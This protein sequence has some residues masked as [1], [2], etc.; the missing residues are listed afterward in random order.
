MNFNYY[1][2]NFAK[3]MKL[4]KNKKTLGI[5][6]RYFTIFVIIAL[7]A[8]KVLLILGIYK[9]FLLFTFILSLITF[10]ILT[11]ISKTYKFLKYFYYS[12][13][14]KLL[15]EIPIDM[16]QLHRGKSIDSIET[17]NFNI[18]M[19]TLYFLS[20]MSSINIKPLLTAF[21]LIFSLYLFIL[22]TIISLIFFLENIIN[23]CMTSLI[24]EFKI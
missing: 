3:N 23:S 7:F 14:S 9:Y 5:Q 10:V 22:Y 8:S 11:L 12:D 4:N 6:K 15:I 2:E 13:I 1:N 16:L 19:H 17:S 21:A 18:P 24:L 20:S